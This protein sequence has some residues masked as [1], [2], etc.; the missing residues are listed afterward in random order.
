MDKHLPT[1]R[2]MRGKNF[3]HLEAQ[4]QVL[5]GTPENQITRVEFL[6][7]LERSRKPHVALGPSPLPPLRNLGQGIP[8]DLVMFSKSFIHRRSHILCVLSMVGKS[9]GDESEAN[10]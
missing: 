6:P 10:R 2:A 7:C 5:F 3:L 8:V 4:P 9:E 1:R